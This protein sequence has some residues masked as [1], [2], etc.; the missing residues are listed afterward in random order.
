MR[1]VAP[2]DP[3]LHNFYGNLGGCLGYLWLNKAAASSGQ[4]LDQNQ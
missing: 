2:D 4:K 1:C 3:L